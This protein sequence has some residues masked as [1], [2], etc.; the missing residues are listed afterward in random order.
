MWI[1]VILETF[2]KEALGMVE[3]VEFEYIFLFIKD[4]SLSLVV[5]PKVRQILDG[6]AW[7]FS[8]SSLFSAISFFWQ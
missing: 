8:C 3:A 4:V 6:E 5:K 1:N 2:K 7:D